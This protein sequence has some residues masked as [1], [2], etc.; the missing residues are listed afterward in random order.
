MQTTGKR[1]KPLW[2]WK[3]MAAGAPSPVR[4]EDAVS[5]WGY[6]VSHEPAQAAAALLLTWFAGLQSGVHDEAHQEDVS[7]LQWLVPVL[8]L[9]KQ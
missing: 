3:K 8:G 2:I 4:F 6:R 1:N 5:V 9:T 7:A